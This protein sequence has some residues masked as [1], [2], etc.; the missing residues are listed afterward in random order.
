MR[1][2]IRLCPR[3]LRNETRGREEEGGERGEVGEGGGVVG[4]GSKIVGKERVDWCILEAPS[5][6]SVLSINFP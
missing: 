1:S 2:S 6:I 5:F 3:K 4:R